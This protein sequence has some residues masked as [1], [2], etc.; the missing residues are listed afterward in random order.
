MSMVYFIKPVGMDG[1]I[2]IGFSAVPATRLESLAAWSPYP[3]EIIGYVGGSFKDEQ[4]LHSSLSD[5]HLHREWFKADEQVKRAVSEVLR[6]GSVDAVKPWLKPIGTIRKQAPRKYDPLV[7]ECQGYKMKIMW[8]QKRLRKLGENGR[9][10]SPKDVDAIMETW[11]RRVWK[12]HENPRPT[13]DEFA[14]LHEYLA[15]PAALS[16][17]PWWVKSKKRPPS[18]AKRMEATQ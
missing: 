2:K 5:S 15:D 7:R 13:E 18:K 17:H 6:L 12:G 1:P 3:L 11:D 8:A 14:R 9:W 10:H 16:I 4:Y